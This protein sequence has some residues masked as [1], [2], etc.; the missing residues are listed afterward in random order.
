MPVML[1]EAEAW[2]VFIVHLHPSF[3]TR[4]PYFCCSPNHPDYDAGK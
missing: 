1:S 2:T 3:F 4:V